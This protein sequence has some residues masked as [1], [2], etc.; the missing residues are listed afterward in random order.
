MS[1]RGKDDPDAKTIVDDVILYAYTVEALL[2][3]F[4]AVLEILQHYRVTVKL[5]KCRFIQTKAKFVGMDILSQ[6]NTPAQ[7]KDEA[8]QKTTHP[9]S[10]TDLRGFIGFVGFYQEFLPL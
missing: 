1:R 2:Q 8:F 9:R 6:G 5:R 3:Y 10:Y 4:E 7:S